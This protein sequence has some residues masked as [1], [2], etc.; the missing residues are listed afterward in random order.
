M[1][2]NE[3]NLD[4]VAGGKGEDRV[5]II[6]SKDGKFFPVPPHVEGFE[7]EEKAKEAFEKLR[8]HGGPPHHR[9]GPHCH[10]KHKPE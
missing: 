1:E 3:N 9:G 8:H 6:E 4:K 10:K 5:K 7:T 2:L